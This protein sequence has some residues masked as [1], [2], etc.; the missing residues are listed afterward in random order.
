MTDISDSDRTSDPHGSW[1][2]DGDGVFVSQ[3][4]GSPWLFHLHPDSS[5]GLGHDLIIMRPGSGM[6]TT[7]SAVRAAAIDHRQWV[8]INQASMIPGA[9]RRL[10]AVAATNGNT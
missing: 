3:N 6:S 2:L 4:D 5:A 8:S 9:V 1:C 10:R 7:A